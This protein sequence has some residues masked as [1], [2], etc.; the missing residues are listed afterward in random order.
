MKKQVKTMKKGKKYISFNT[1]EISVLLGGL[2]ELLNLEKADLA[3]LQVRILQERLRL[4]HE[5]LTYLKLK[6]VR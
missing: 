1:I 3:K 4:Y 5:R 6:S 2:S